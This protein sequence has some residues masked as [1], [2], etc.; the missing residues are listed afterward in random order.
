MSTSVMT[1]TRRT[2]AVVVAVL[3]AGLCQCDVLAQSALELTRVATGLTNPLYATHAPGD[4]QRLFVVEKTGA[5]KILNL[6]SGTV[7]ATP[8]MTAA[9]TSAG[10]GLTTDSERGLLGL[11]F[12]PNYQSNGRF[13]IN[14][15]DSAG[16]TWTPPAPATC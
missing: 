13:F 2:A 9:V 1:A 8:F 16:T 14:S 15:T 5:I 6:A 11:A 4:P 7:S 3:A 10:I 12:H